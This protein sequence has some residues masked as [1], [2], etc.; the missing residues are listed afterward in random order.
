MFTPIFRSNVTVYTALVKCTDLLLTGVIVEM[1]L[2][3]ST[4]SKVSS[5]SVY[6]TK[7]VYAVKLFLE[8]GGNVARNM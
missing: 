1:E 7:A 5:R 3:C 4:V 2:L 8:M 6:C